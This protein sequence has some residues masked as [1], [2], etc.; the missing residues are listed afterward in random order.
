MRQKDR[1][2]RSVC[3]IG[4]VTSWA[5][6]AYLDELGQVGRNQAVALVG[7][8]PYN[9]D[10]GKKSGK[11]RIRGGRAKIRSCL[12]M[13]AKTAAQHNPVIKPYV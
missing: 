13:A 4:E 11:R 8:A 6:I 10:S 9:R 1:I 3:G 7:V 2:F 5:L 12:Y